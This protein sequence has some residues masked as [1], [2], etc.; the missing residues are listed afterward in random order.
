[1]GARGPNK[2]TGHVDPWRPK[3]KVFSNAFVYEVYRTALLF[4]IRRSLEDE[5]LEMP[6]ST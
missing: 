3:A 4:G 5:K 2:P 1:M 6:S